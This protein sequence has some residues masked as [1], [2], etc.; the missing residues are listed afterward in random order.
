MERT[1]ITDADAVKGAAGGIGKH[2][3]EE[4]AGVTLH[5]E[6]IEADVDGV[7]RL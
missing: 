1:P 4:E 6:R 2:L 7:K 3:E 5:K